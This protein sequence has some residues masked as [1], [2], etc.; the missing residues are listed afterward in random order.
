MYNVRLSSFE[1][2]WDRNTESL[3]FHSENNCSANNTTDR[4]NISQIYR[5]LSFYRCKAE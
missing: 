5:T 1:Q 4:A 3:N 2:R